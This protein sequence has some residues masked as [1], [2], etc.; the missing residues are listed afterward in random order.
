MSYIVN[1]S[2]GNIAAVVNDG[3]IDA[4]TSLNLIGKGYPNY[5]ETVAENLVALM[6]NFANSVAPRNPLPGQLWYNKS[7]QQLEIYSGT[8][9][10][11]VNNVDI[12]SSSP[13]AP[14]TGDF[15]YNTT[16]KQ[17]SFYREGAW[18]V[19]APSY[20]AAQGRAEVVTE[21]FRDQDGNNHTVLAMYT[22]GRRTVVISGDAEFSTLPYVVGFGVV[23]P[24]INIADPTSGISDAVLNGTA[25]VSLIA[26]GLDP[27]ADATY[28]HANAD[29]STTGNLTVNNTTFTLGTAGNLSI[30]SDGSIEMTAVGDA[31]LIINGYG[32][33]SLRLD[34]STNWISV[35]KTTP[36]ADLDVGGAI[37]A[38][39]TITAQQGFYFSSASQSSITSDATSLTV[40]QGGSDSIVIVDGV[41]NIDSTDT[42]LSGNLQV[43]GEIVADGN[44][45][46][47]TT[48]TVGEHATNKT[49][50]D[51]LTLNN[52]LP[53]GSIIMWYGEYQNVPTGWSICDGTGGTPDLRDRFV[54]GAGL[55]AT[56]GTQGGANF[57]TLNT[58]TVG[59]HVHSGTVAAGGD[60]DH[61]GQT[62]GHALTAEEIANH[63]HTFVNVYAL[64][65]D[66]NPP[67]LDRNGNRVQRY[68]GWN[69]DHDNDSGDPA[70][71]DSITDP[72]GNSSP[73]THD[74]SA[75]GTHT[76]SFTSGSAG[77]HSHVI[78][79][80]D[81]RPAWTALYYIMKTSM[82][83]Q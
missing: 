58:N 10:T 55:S 20:T 24:G 53:I 32:G 14:A 8:Q 26:D 57:T 61:S 19:L 22:N 13:Q 75:S 80:Q 40:T 1:R 63:Q 62:A 43:N 50:V 72:A 65:D 74:I 60:H 41:V 64:R 70:Q 46:V 5:A 52:T 73:H 18:K 77:S 47:A 33:S 59:D 7:M 23:K 29:T 48:P 49:Y 36:S 44:V 17:L 3:V 6:E 54:M 11:P 34:N 76:H 51:A 28:M 42:D 82:V 16:T 39:E 56:Y 15:W 25:S 81:M 35:N 27:V 38:D 67:L 83:L 69:D 9:F 78:S 12:S 2:D 21:T 79:N 30:I 37:N 4:T 31:P 45:S 68:D 66:A 71:F